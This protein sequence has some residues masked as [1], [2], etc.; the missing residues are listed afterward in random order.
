[1]GS[2]NTNFIVIGVFMPT[3]TER[4]QQ[5][6]HNY[7]AKEEH[8]PTS[9]RE[10]VEWAV[11]AGLL[12][13]PEID[14]YDVLAGQMAS[15][16]RDEYDT[17]AKGRRYRLN[18]AVRVSKGGV[19]QTFWA[20]MGFAPHEHMEK[21]FTQRREQIVGDNMQLKTDV[22]VYNDMNRGKRPEVQLVLDYTDDV[23]EREAI[24]HVPPKKNAVAA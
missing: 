23:A 13:L 1:M 14:P 6:W 10:A 18:H 5:I 17:D 15:A 2:G 21:A 7:D 4:L 20:V 9:A 19:Q 12:D 22:D 8:R 11:N 3:K 16:L 24:S